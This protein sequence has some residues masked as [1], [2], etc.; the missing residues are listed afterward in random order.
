MSSLVRHVKKIIILIMLVVDVSQFLQISTAMN[1][2]HLI[3]IPMPITL[4]EHL[5]CS[6]L[7]ITQL[8]RLSIILV[9]NVKINISKDKQV[10]Y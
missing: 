5:K 1:L 9:I 4:L 3:S 8:M 7:T 6:I 10:F 2:K